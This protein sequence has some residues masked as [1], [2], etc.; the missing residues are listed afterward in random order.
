MIAVISEDHI[1]Q[2]VIQE[3]IDLGYSYINGADISLDGVSQ[4]RA[5]DE[6]NLENLVSNLKSKRSSKLTFQFLSILL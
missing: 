3:F 4:E 1:E 5:Y 6:V 2:I